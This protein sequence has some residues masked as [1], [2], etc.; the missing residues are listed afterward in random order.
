M[1]NNKHIS[2]LGSLIYNWSKMFVGT[3]QRVLKH[4]CLK[5]TMSKNNLL[6]HKSGLLHCYS[7]CYFIVQED[8]GK[9]E[10]NEMKKYKSVRKNFQQQGKHSR[11]SAFILALKRTFYSSGFQATEGLNFCVCS[12]PLQVDYDDDTRSLTNS[13]KKRKKKKKSNNKD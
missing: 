2:I 1:V 13:Q 11:F 6:D 5:S 10:L 3:H 7:T 8:M 4:I 9:W 12:T